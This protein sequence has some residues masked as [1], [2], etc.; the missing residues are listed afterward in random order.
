MLGAGGNDIALL[1]RLAAA[2]RCVAP[3]RYIAAAGLKFEPENLFW[4]RLVEQLPEAPAVNEG[5]MPHPTRFVSMT[6]MT[7]AGIGRVTVWIRPR[8]DLAMANG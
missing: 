7:R 1:A 5:V 4:R 8:P 3:V 6:G 2:E